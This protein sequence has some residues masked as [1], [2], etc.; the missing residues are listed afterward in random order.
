VIAM[1]AAAIGPPE[2]RRRLPPEQRRAQLLEIAI[3]VFADRG[4]GAARHAEIAER[5][6][7]AV[8]TVFAYFETREALV[9]AVLDKVADLF[10]QAAER[11]HGQ[12]KGCVEILREVGDAFVDFLVTHRSH[13]IVWLEWGSAVREDVWPRYREFTERIVAITKKTL[14]RGQH[15]GCV[16]P[17]ADIESLARLFASSS[18]SIARLQLSDV[19]PETVAR[20]QET[21]LRA[22]VR[23]A[24]LA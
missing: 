23:E 10:L 19:D 16:D 22:I 15:E 3:D 5:A 13:A 7:V 8:S 18:Q 12:D 14:R 24:A 4:L 1:S 9:D 21:V 17:D 11:I 6:G 2:K 20:F